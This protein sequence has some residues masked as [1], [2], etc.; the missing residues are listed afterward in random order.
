MLGIGH[1]FDNPYNSL[2]RRGVSSGYLGSTQHIHCDLN[3]LNTQ[4]FKTLVL[5][6]IVR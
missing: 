4:R 2:D 3:L 5:P 6:Y 1:N